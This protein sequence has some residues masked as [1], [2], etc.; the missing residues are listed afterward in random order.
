M[1]L[2]KSLALSLA[3]GCVALP[4]FAEPA[5]K[6][7]ARAEAKS[8]SKNAGD[9]AAQRKARL[10]KALEKQGL[11]QAKAQSV[12]NVLAK[13]RPELQTVRKDMMSA[14]RA[15]KDDN[16][17]NDAA[18]KQKIADGKKKLEAIRQRRQAELAKILTPAE[19]EKVAKLLDRKGKRG[20][21]NKPKGKRGQ[22]A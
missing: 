15:L 4:A 11:S 17:A 5:P 10:T 7:P 6:A 13:F 9:K 21:A 18:A 19:R 1:R 3:I 12:V 14:R 2:F 22:S 20:K 8:K 16:S